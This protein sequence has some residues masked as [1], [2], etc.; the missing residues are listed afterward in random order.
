MKQDEATAAAWFEKAAR[1]GDAYAKRML[2]RL[3]V[4]AGQARC[5]L[6]S[7][8]RYLEPLRTHPNPSPELILRW[9]KRL[10]PEFGLDTALVLAV[11]RAESN[12]NPKALSNKNARGLMQ[13]I[14]ATAKR[15]G[16]RDIWDPLQNIRGGMAYL[17]W[18]LDTFAGNEKLALAG[19]NASENAV[20]RYRG[21]P[22]YAET[23]NYVR[24]ISRWRRT[25]PSRILQTS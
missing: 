1:Q 2:K 6:S 10:A 12:F 19:Y 9:V 16:V 13:L 7:G 8:E 24:K 21:I 18:L 5:I 22:P 20:V 3:P 25:S 17:R 15:F 23:R 11:I 4:P 14:P